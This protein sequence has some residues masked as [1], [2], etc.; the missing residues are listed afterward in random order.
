MSDQPIR[1]PELH[2]HIGKLFETSLKI[3][4]PIQQLHQIREKIGARGYQ[5]F[6]KSGIRSEM[7][8]LQQVLHSLHTEML[9]IDELLK[10]GVK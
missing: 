2:R 10:K 6:D 5:E 3:S 8:Q 7:G 4:W 1:A 9:L